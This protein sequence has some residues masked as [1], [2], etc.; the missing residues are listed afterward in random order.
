MSVLRLSERV[1]AVH[2]AFNRGDDRKD[3]AFS[4]ARDVEAM[5]ADLTSLRSQLTS[6][7]EE[8]DALL[9]LLLRWKTAFGLGPSRLDLDTDLAPARLTSTT[10]NSTVAPVM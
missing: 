7:T 8:R 2:H 10:K 9:G 3:A 1:R 4:L 6:L 5:E